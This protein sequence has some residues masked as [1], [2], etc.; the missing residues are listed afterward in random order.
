MKSLY[1]YLLTALILA[2]AFAMF[3]RQSNRQVESAMPIDAF[4]L[5]TYEVPANLRHQLR[6]LMNQH[7]R[8][9]S[10]DGPSIARVEML[11]GGQLALIGPVEVQKGF[12]EVVSK[13]QTVEPSV[14]LNYELDCWV[15]LGPADL[16]AT[17]SAD[18]S[19]MELE[20]WL[21]Q[22]GAEVEVMEHLRLIGAEGS[23][24]QIIGTLFRAEPELAMNG[25]QWVGELEIIGTGEYGVS[26]GLSTQLAL[27]PNR[28]ALIGGSSIDYHGND[29]RILDLLARQ[30]QIYY[31]VRIQNA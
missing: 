27:S 22:L 18:L 6:E 14:T 3:F 9:V 30:G 26:T 19:K 28:P 5:A 16:W 1:F 8:A 15:V 4:R 25:Q 11:P 31:I 7:F 29:K 23:R 2:L 12:A 13:L 20:T 17:R 24:T 21:E 10:G